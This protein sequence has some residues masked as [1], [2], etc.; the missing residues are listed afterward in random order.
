MRYLLDALAADRKFA[1]G[2]QEAYAL[3]AYSPGAEARV[4][5]AWEAREVKPIFYSDE[6]GH[7]AL[8]RTL[9]L[10]AEQKLNGL[11]ARA[12]IIRSLASK[13]PESLEP[14]ERKQL[15]W[16]IRE[17]SGYC[18]REFSTLEPV[19]PLGWLDIL[20]GEELGLKSTRTSN[21]SLVTSSELEGQLNLQRVPLFIGQWLSRHICEPELLRWILSGGGL[22]HRDFREMIRRVLSRDFCPWPKSLTVVW[23]ML[24]S[25]PPIVRRPENFFYG[26]LAAE[27]RS[28]AW[29][30]IL[31]LELLKGLEPFLSLSP[32]MDFAALLR[33]SAPPL[34]R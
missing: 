22:L 34:N 14:R 1:T 9:R 26:H 30:Q 28:G 16:A 11:T 15:V 5:A 29:N 25:D 19:P 23:Q 12:A 18:A 6:K 27:L 8:H 31:K 17:P 2:P 7:V 20:P 10:W 24:S 21:G 33:D 13:D 3:V 32:A 4:R